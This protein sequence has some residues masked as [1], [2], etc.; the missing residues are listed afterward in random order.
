VRQNIIQMI[1]H[2]AE[3]HSAHAL[4]PPPPATF[5]NPDQPSTS[6]VN[7]VGCEKECHQV[8]DDDDGMGPLAL[9][10]PVADEPGTVCTA[11]LV[12]NRRLSQETAAPSLPSDADDINVQVKV[13]VRGPADQNPRHTMCISACKMRAHSETFVGLLDDLLV[14]WSPGTEVSLILSVDDSDEADALLALLMLVDDTEPPVATTGSIGLLMLMHMLAEKLQLSRAFE[15]TGHHLHDLKLARQALSTLDMGVIVKLSHLGRDTT[16]PPHVAVECRTRLLRLVDS[17]YIYSDSA[18][19]CK[20]FRLPF[21]AAVEVLASNSL[22]ITSEDDAVVFMCAYLHIRTAPGDERRLQMAERCIRAA[23]LSPGFVGGVVRH[24]PW[25]FDSRR[26]MWRAVLERKE[27]DQHT[28]P[29]AWR[30]NM[31]PRVLV[32]L[33]PLTSPEATVQWPTPPS[34]GLTLTWNVPRKHL[35]S[36]LSGHHVHHSEPRVLYKG[37]MWGFTL[38]SSPN[39]NEPGR[40]LS[41]RLYVCESQ[42]LHDGKARP[43]ELQWFVQGLVQLQVGTVLRL[44]KT[45]GVKEHVVLR[46]PCNIARMRIRTRQPSDGHLTVQLVLADCLV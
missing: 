11:D 43:D 44:T 27:E 30:A 3:L 12:M 31:R 25:L 4:P 37:F 26:D 6:P 18:K 39:E 19:M 20:F 34:P 9:L 29:R 16:Y 17:A 14:D 36:R 21:E 45:S 2:L 15:A 8:R 23:H 28:L 33:P 5:L 35:D 22:R 41:V 7:D 10:S 13:N 32:E 24:I 38:E 42:W 1:M 40:S 46:R